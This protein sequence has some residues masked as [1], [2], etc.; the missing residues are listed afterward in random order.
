MFRVKKFR[1]NALTLAAALA[2]PAL[3]A[4]PASAGVIHFTQIS[5]AF[6]N[7]I[8]VDYYEPTNE[9][10]LSANYS[11]GLPHNLEKIDFAGNHTQWSTLSGADDELKIATARSGNAG[12]FAAGT[13]FT[14]NGVA[15]QIVRVSADGA[16]VLNPWVTLPGAT[17]L[18]RGSLYVD[19]TG[20]WGGDLITVTTTGELYRV[21][22][23]G[24]TTKVRDS[25]N[26]HLEGLMTV[27]ND[28][29]KYGPIAGKAIAGA[30]DQGLMYAFDPDGSFTTYSVGV[31]IE[32]IDFIEPGGNFFG[33]NYG[34]GKIL[35]APAA[36]FAG[37]VGEILLTQEFHGGVGIFKLH[38]NGSSFETTEYTAAGPAI[39]QWEHVTFARAG[40]VEIEPTVPL[41]ATA[42]GG[43]VLL[44]S[45]LA[46]KRIRKIAQR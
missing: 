11:N 25:V 1:I 12:G 37:D 22:N 43:L 36:D 4:A 7:P 38:W 21:T 42:L 5:T 13:V 14:G 32:D 9:V 28:V 10:I 45:T 31:N 6:S 2:L 18:L 33:V 41:P 19:R 27:P 29:A 46:A 3:A 16:S 44:G 17:G 34:T 24:G 30:E 8:G 40:I 35:G 20:V 23:A 26:T 39:G 15:G